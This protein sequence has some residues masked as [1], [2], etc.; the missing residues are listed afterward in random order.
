MSEIPC[1]ARYTVPVLRSLFAEGL[2]KTSLAS[3]LLFSFLLLQSEDKLRRSQ[4]QGLI[5]QRFVT[6][7]HYLVFN[8]HRRP[9]VSLFGKSNK[10]PRYRL[11]SP[12]GQVKKTNRRGRFFSSSHPHSVTLAARRSL[13][14]GLVTRDSIHQPFPVCQPLRQSFSNLFKSF[15]RRL[16]ASLCRWLFGPATRVSISEPRPLCQGF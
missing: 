7:F 10:K 11:D 9:G 12:L 13:L 8:V 14:F 5:A 4:Q 2:V 1:P 15:L 3:L 6:R 16:S